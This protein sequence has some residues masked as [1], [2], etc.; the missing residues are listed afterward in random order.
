M[1][2]RSRT[3][4]LIADLRAAWQADR[5]PPGGPR[6]TGYPVDRPRPVR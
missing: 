4:L 6:V 2:V 5:L 1:R 3:R